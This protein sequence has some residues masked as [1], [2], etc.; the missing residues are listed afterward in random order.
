MVIMVIIVTGYNG[1]WRWRSVMTMMKVTDDEKITDDDGH[2][3][4]MMEITNDKKHWWCRDLMMKS[5]D[6]VTN[7]GG[8]W[9]FIVA[10]EFMQ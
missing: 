1:Q 2:W 5:T 3:S 7:D 4:L 6:D 10:L 9:C 8:Y